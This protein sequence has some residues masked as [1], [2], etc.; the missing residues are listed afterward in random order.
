[1][2]TMR[3][4]TKGHAV[5]LGCS[6]NGRSGKRIVIGFDEETFDEIRG[7][8]LKRQS[9]F[10]EVVRELVEFGLIDLKEANT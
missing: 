9:S 4:R 10:A 2:T 6:V 1:M 3:R 7:I 8:A 5:G